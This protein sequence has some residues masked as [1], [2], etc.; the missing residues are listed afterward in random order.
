M[1]PIHHC[2]WVSLYRK[3]MQAPSRSPM[4]WTSTKFQGP[5]PSSICPWHHL[6]MA[7]LYIADSYDVMQHFTYY[8]C[9]VRRRLAQIASGGAGDA[10]SCCIPRP[11]KVPDHLRLALHLVLDW[12]LCS[13]CVGEPGGEM[14]L[15]KS[16][17]NTT[18][19]L[20]E[21]WSIL[22]LTSWGTFELW[23]SVLLDS[24]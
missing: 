9:I 8:V 2:R 24:D 3:L 6:N 14:A 16:G 12:S 1:N 18:A 7:E 13:G 4:S 15:E 5:S 21:C 19:A 17:G 23:M 20:D 10:A 22:K 11:H